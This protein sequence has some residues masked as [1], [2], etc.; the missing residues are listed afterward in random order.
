MSSRRISLNC[1]K[2]GTKC[3]DVLLPFSRYEECPHCTV[4]LHC[5]RQCRHYQPTL[6]DGCSQDR[7]DFQ[8]EKEKANF[9]DFF[10]AK[11]D[12]F[13]ATDNQQ[14][15]EARRKLDELFGDMA[16]PLPDAPA[17]TELSEAEKALLEL[18][19]LFEQSE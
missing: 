7:A 13:V 8:L 4:D 1:W 2:C 5:C 3:K 9:C 16:E 12:A 17:S 15:L 14:E 18:E 19:Q 11:P 10:H 6:A